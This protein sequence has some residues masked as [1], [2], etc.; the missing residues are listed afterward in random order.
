MRYLMTS[1]A[2]GAALGAVHGAGRGWRDLRRDVPQNLR[3][4]EHLI[5]YL[6]EPTLLDGIS[7]LCVGPWVPLVTP[8]WFL[9]QQSRCPAHKPIMK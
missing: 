5:H 3:R 6:A 7:G 9:R 8:L 2:I 1:A 4:A